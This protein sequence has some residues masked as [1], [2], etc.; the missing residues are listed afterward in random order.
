MSSSFTSKPTQKKK[1][2][3][4]KVNQSLIRGSK[5]TTKEKYEVVKVSDTKLKFRKVNPNAKH[6]TLIFFISITTIRI[7]TIKSAK[8]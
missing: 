8:K 4:T 7:L 6:I 5:L 1:V 3:F 2:L